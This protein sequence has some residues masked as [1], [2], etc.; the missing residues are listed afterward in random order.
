MDEMGA[1]ELI[2]DRLRVHH[3]DR[4]VADA[5]LLAPARSPVVPDVES[6]AEERLD[7]RGPGTP[8]GA[9]EFDVAIAPL[10]VGELERVVAELA[11]VRSPRAHLALLV[12]DR[13]VIG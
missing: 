3:E 5:P 12:D 11:H 8:A 13:V 7:V 1:G 2:E 6:G 4:A 9:H 10:V